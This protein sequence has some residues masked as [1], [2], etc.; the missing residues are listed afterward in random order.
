MPHLSWVKICAVRS[1]FKTILWVTGYSPFANI[2]YCLSLC[3]S[4][5]TLS[6][7]SLLKSAL[8]CPVDEKGAFEMQVCHSQTACACV[9]FCIDFCV[10]GYLSKCLCVY[11]CAYVSACVFVFVFTCVY[12]DSQNTTKQILSIWVLTFLI[13]LQ[14]QQIFLEGGDFQFSNSLWVNNLLTS[15]LNGLGLILRFC[16]FF[17]TQSPYKIL[18][19]NHLKHLNRSPI[20]LHVHV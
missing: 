5:Y 10:S 1:P 11:L 17:W 2:T 19:L 18:S 3:N 16:P 6:V 9:L 12:T 7:I 15:P 13:E 20:I 4:D 8:R 14:H